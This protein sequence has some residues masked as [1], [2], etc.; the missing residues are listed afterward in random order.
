VSD[1][2][3][4]IRR[5]ELLAGL[6][7]GVAGAVVMPGVAAHTR[8]GA[9]RA[10]INDAGQT[11]AG[12]P[13]AADPALPRLLDDHRLAMLGGIADQLMP[14]ARATGVAGLLDR[15]LA[16]ESAAAQRRFLNALGAF[17]RDARD[18]HGKGWM[19]I[20]GA[21]QEEIL[22]AASALASARPPSPAWSRGQPIERPDGSPSLPAN[23]RDHLDHLKDWVQRAYFTT[24]AGMKEFGFAGAT[25]FESFPG[26]PHPGDVHS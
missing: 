11:P 20:S 26:C 17:E 9:D 22:G 7:A 6:A 14:G 16:V 2:A 23:L 19:E 18:R 25:A 12:S 5:R 1:P 10:R 4:T 21:Q 13:S 24:A 15:V 3:K 8:A